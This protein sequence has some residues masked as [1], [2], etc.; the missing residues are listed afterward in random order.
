M[1]YYISVAKYFEKEA[2]IF[3]INY[4]NPHYVAWIPWEYTLKWGVRVKRENDDSTTIEEFPNYEKAC[5][6]VLANFYNYD[7]YNEGEIEYS[8]MIVDLVTL[9]VTN[10]INTN[11]IDT[12]F[13]KEEEYKNEFVLAINKV[14]T[15]KA[16]TNGLGLKLK[17]K[18]Y[19]KQFALAIEKVLA[20]KAFTLGLALKLSMRN[21]GFDLS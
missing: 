10:Y 13:H 6:S 3:N 21:C 1:R 2:C 12:F 7:L 16:F 19:K 8:W 18:E 15:S 14:L 17:E 20:S 9:E 5:E 4:A 11:D